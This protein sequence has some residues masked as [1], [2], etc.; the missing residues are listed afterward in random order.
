[1]SCYLRVTVCNCGSLELVLHVG[2]SRVALNQSLGGRVVFGG[3]NAGLVVILLS[4]VFVVVSGHGCGLEGRAEYCDSVVG[5]FGV[6]SREG[7]SLLKLRVAYVEFVIDLSDGG[8][9]FLLGDINE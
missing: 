8:G 4:V 6:L 7:H 1:M 3:G 5:R 2:V 9:V